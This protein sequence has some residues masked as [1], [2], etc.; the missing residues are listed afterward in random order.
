MVV[1][2][3]LLNNGS[4]LFDFTNLLMLTYFSEEL[5]PMLNE[6]AG[7]PADTELFLFEEIKP[8]LVERISNFNEPLE[9]VRCQFCT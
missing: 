8:N 9:K 5:I 1:G 4:C 2:K 7:F 3:P 6:R